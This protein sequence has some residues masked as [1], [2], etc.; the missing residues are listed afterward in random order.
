[1]TNWKERILGLIRKRGIPEDPPRDPEELRK[2]F[3]IRYRALKELLTS[4]SKALDLMTE[5]E[6]ALDGEKPFGMSFVRSRAA[7]V[8]VNVWRMLKYLNALGPEKYQ[9]LFERYQI[10]NS[11]IISIIDSERSALDGPLIIPLY[12]M[13]NAKIDLVGSKMFNLGMIGNEPGLE[14]PDGFVITSRAYDLFMDHKDLRGEINRRAQAKGGQGSEDILTLC[15]NLQQLI[16]DQPLPAELED[17]IIGAYE[18]LAVRLGYRPNLSVR[19]SA[20]GEDV[21]GASFAG[22]FHSE[23]NVSPENLIHAYKTVVGSKYGAS[24][25]SYRFNRGIPDDRISMCVGA[26]E[27]IDSAAGGVV[28]TTD[29]FDS[30]SNTLTI[31]S[32]FGLPKGV[33]TGSVAVDSFILIKTRDL[34]IVKKTIVEKLEKFVCEK[35]EGTRKS[36][37]EEEFVHAPSIEDNTVINLARIALKLESSFCSA[38][39]VEWLI[40]RD[41]K[42]KI[43][44]SRTLEAAHKSLRFRRG[45]VMES[46][47]SNVLITGAITASRGAGS[48]QVFIARNSA[49]ILSFP[50]GAILVV[51]TAA[52]RWAPLLSRAAALVAETGSMAGHLA[53]VAR[54]F[55]VPALFG[56]IN[57][58]TLLQQGQIITVDADN[59]RIH[60]GRLES[61]LNRQISRPNLMQGSPVWETLK[62]VSQYICPL[63]LIDAD[64][65]DFR[66]NKCL[67]MHD[68][69]RFVHEKGVQEMFNFGEHYGYPARGAKRLKCDVPMQ[70]WVMDLDDGFSE[71]VD[72]DLVNI[73]QIVSKPML[74]LWN[75]IITVPWAGP[76]RIEAGGFMSVLVRSTH[77]PDLEPTIASTYSARNYFM[78][79]K[80][81]LFFFSRLGYHLSTVEALVGA[82]SSENYVGFSFKG[83]AADDH[84][85]AR[86][87][88]LI[89]DI[90]AENGFRTRLT[91][92][93]LTARVDH[94]DEE[95]MI[96]KLAILGYLITH[97][98]Q[99]DMAMGSERAIENYRTKFREDIKKLLNLL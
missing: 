96:Q 99:C 24:A 89:A 30:S 20:L 46:H 37:V 29:P 11:R 43:L 78:I 77:N 69:T 76:P 79:S 6:M 59:K 28:Y 10:I 7:G 26:M 2:L 21:A 12:S 66:Q 45:E 32:T 44:Q 92:D 3:R 35:G 17:A 68:I 33:V 86:R 18:D 75:G 50:A 65:P 47:G 52:P 88:K 70:W 34:K 81:F 93:R 95:S 82:R 31:F 4:N 23:L 48:G 8:S 97:A 58:T 19:S 98:R 84:R 73:E 49:D 80:N 40:T 53:N 94:L 36:Q 27:M 62:N 63:N 71:K 64:S 22:Q 67:T 38:Q 54:E 55:G 1:M 51:S 87:A 72:G 13:N 14:T 74:A 39:D 91:G 90:L 16:I 25:T 41:G 83:G 15:S 60:N 9:D 42:I 61:L 5:M 56:T 57:A 85:R